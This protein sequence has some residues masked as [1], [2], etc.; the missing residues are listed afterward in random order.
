MH[1]I[2]SLL[3]RHKAIIRVKRKKR[4]LWIISIN[5]RDPLFLYPRGRCKWTER[6]RKEDEYHNYRNFDLIYSPY[7]YYITVHTRKVHIMGNAAVFII[8][9]KRSNKKKTDALTPLASNIFAILAYSGKKKLVLLDDH[10]FGTCCDIKKPIVSNWFYTGRYSI[11]STMIS[12]KSCILYFKW[13]LFIHIHTFN[14][15]CKRAAINALLLLFIIFY[16]YKFYLFFLMPLDNGLH[17]IN[18]RRMARLDG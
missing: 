4:I 14:Y 11:N 8:V 16:V 17:N 15:K 1:W 6:Q 9:I 13:N 18:S 7:I 10:P 3:W 2:A 12:P 5:A